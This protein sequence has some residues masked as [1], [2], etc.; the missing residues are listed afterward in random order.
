MHCT[1]THKHTHT[2]THTHTETQT[3]TQTH[4]LF[5]SFNKPPPSQKKGIHGNN[6]RTFPRHLM[7]KILK[8]VF[9]KTHESPNLG[10]LKKWHLNPK[11][12]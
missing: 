10:Q 2:H 4:T 9:F 5:T 11:Q 8:N 12:K 6:L 7:T 3:Q 1:H